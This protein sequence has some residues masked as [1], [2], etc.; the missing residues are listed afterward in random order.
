MWKGRKQKAK[1]IRGKTRTPKNHCFGFGFGA[2]IGTE[3][4]ISRESLDYY[5][6]VEFKRNTAQ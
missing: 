1:Q 6:K 5:T 2:K 3:N 4:S